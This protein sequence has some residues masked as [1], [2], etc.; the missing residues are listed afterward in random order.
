MT[1]RRAADQNSP[2][3]LT[4]LG[5]MYLLGLGSAKDEA[6]SVALFEKASELGYAEAQYYL[7]QILTA[8]GVV[9]RDETHAAIWLRKAASQGYVPA[10]Q[11]LRD[12]CERGIRPACE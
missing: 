9:P 8:G 11:P 4:N 3:G 6:A 7:G 10:A 2:A 1:A 5:W 12:L